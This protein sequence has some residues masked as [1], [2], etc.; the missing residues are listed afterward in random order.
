MSEM[1][2][3]LLSVPVWP[4]KVPVDLCLGKQL[5][6]VFQEGPSSVK[7]TQELIRGRHQE[8]VCSFRNYQRKNRMFQFYRDQL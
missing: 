8:R 3:K 5:S 2:L 1:C 7:V 6:S 4:E